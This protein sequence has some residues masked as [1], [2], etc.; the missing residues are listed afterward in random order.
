MMGHGRRAR[1]QAVCSSW[2]RPT[3]LVVAV[4]IAAGL[5]VRIWILRTPAIGYLDSDEAVPGLMARHL[6]HGEV[7]VFYWGQSYGGTPE[8]GLIAALFGITGPSTT[9]LRLVPIALYAIS[10]LVLWRIGRRTIGERV[11]TVAALLFW[12]WPAYFVW[13]STREYG[14]YGV[15]LLTGMLVV[16][17]ALRLRERPNAYDAGFL[18][19]AL[20]YGWWTSPQIV[21]VAVPAVAWLAWRQPR[22]WRYTPLVVLMAGGAAAPWLSWNIGHH[23]ASLHPDP[24][25]PS[26]YGFRL[27]RFFLDALPTALGL[28]VLFV[29]DW[30]PEPLLGEILFSALCVV[31]LAVLL[32]AR[33]SLELVL[34]IL[35]PFPFIYA[36]SP[37]TGFRIEPRYLGLLAPLLA[38]L[39]ALLVA[40]LLKDL[41]IAAV[42]LAGALALTA[43]S[44]VRLRDA[45]VIA[46]NA[47]DVQAPV[48]LGPLVRTL[49]RDHVTRAWADYWV[50]FRIIFLTNERIIAAPT[51]EPRYPLYNA[52]VSASQQPAHIFVAGTSEEPAQRPELLKAGYER[53]RTGDFVVYVP[54][55][56]RRP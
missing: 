35:L 21:L 12:I 41:R 4:A 40:P 53:L 26:S 33:R 11:A 30:L 44:L 19:L 9:T 42:A 50:A 47:P 23:W 27:A 17:L 10:G 5:V 25:L 48:E 8:V 45:D 24:G 7:S 49:E 38:P 29:R 32:R 22:V 6:L 13:R 16:L 56:H 34:A 37:F 46:P 1:V 51:E 36:S 2:R 52:I 54:R 28:R 55:T 39:L 14:Y 15:L 31:L 18:G 3:T 43:V 20:G